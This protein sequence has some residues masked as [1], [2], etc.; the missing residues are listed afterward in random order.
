M[1][2]CAIPHL[3]PLSLA[4]GPWV[5]GMTDELALESMTWLEVAQ[6]IEAGR[7]LVVVPFGAVEQHGPHLPIGT[8]A[9][10]GDEIGRRTAERLDGILAPTVRIGCSS[11]HMSFSGTIS[12]EHETLIRVAMDTARSLAA[13]GFSRVYLL[14]THYGNFAPVVAAL[15][16]LKEEHLGGTQVVGPGPNYAEML[17]EAILDASKE[18]DIPASQSG[19]HCGEWETSLMLALRPELV[20]MD[21]AEPGYTGDL[22]SAAEAIREYGIDALAANGV[23]GDPTLASPAHGQR[24]LDR[25]V[26]LAAATLAAPAS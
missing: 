12:L 19:I 9:I 17:D 11:H 7:D 5:P 3:Q 6:Q 2:T 14:P 24:Y 1:L 10:I 26:D 15:Q 8:D 25:L 4:A 23:V 16:R 18:F 20:R 13:H 21:Q 22:S